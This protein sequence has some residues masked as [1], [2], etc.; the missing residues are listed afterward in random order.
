LTVIRRTTAGAE[1]DL[2]WPVP[3]AL[4][5]GAI[6]VYMVPLLRLWDLSHAQHSRTNFGI[7]AAAFAAGAAL[8]RPPSPLA[9]LSADSPNSVFSNC[10]GR[11]FRGDIFKLR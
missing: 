11:V 9:P 10:A 4:R 7:F 8:P 2:G 5:Q 3:F 1:A 6:A